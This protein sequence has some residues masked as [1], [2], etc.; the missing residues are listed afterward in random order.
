MAVCGDV[1]RMD[2]LCAE[3]SLDPAFSFKNH[4]Y[5]KQQW[6]SHFNNWFEIDSSCGF[7][8]LSLTKI[9][10]ADEIYRKAKKLKKNSGEIGA[11]LLGTNSL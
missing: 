2:H 5:A 3:I 7:F 9:W 8:F 6:R 11:Y 4:K 1:V 10:H